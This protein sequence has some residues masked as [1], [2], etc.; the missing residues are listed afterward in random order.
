LY[1]VTG[2]LSASPR[3]SVSCHVI[4]LRTLLLKPAKGREP[5]T[6][7]VAGSGQV[8]RCAVETRADL[9]FVLSA[10]LYR[11]LGTGS[12]ASFLPYGNA[13]DQ[14]EQL[15]REHVM[16][17]AGNVPVIA[18]I[19]GHDPTRPL[20]ERFQR[21]RALGVSGVVNWPAVGFVDGT[22]RALIEAEG[23]G[24]DAE[25]DMLQQARAAGFSTFG[26][27]LQPEDVERLAPGADAFVLDLG[28]TRSV[29]DVQTKGDE[30]RQAIARLNSMMRAAE[31]S[32]PNRLCLAFGGPITEAEDV[33]QIFRHSGVHGFAGGSV[34]ER[35]P[36]HDAVSSTIRR[37][38]SVA[39][40]RLA[41]S[42]AHSFGDMIGC[43]S[44]MRQVFDLIR[45]AAP[46]DVNICIEG[47]SGT[48]KELVATQLHRLSKRADQPFVTLNCG[49]LPES[50]LESELFGH[51]KGAFTGAERRRPGKFELAHRG[52]LFLDEIGDLSPRGQVALLRVLQQREVIRVG[53]ETPIPVDV[54]VFCASNRPLARLVEVGDFRADLYYR[55]NALTIELPPLR[56]RPEDLPPLVEAVLAELRVRLGRPGLRLSMAFEEKLRQHAWPGNVREL[57]HVITQ[58]ALREEEPLLGGT[59]FIPQAAR[60]ERRS[61]DGFTDQFSTESRRTRAEQA[62]R[63]ANGNKSRAA[64]TLGVTRKT[65]YA[66]LRET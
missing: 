43:G 49:A 23:L 22:L 32:G 61:L 12:L 13:N 38:K 37:F 39:A 24:V 6:A 53:G 14:T 65:F 31:R 29:R 55:L 51:E 46:H 54:R 2:A 45:R 40:G 20:G 66:W 9:L 42:E 3:L 5:L 1:T 60:P 15:L 26:F 17:R 50:L 27:A 33:E 10:G 16:P 35:I 59:F 36:V 34:F 58:A 8:T 30:L 28:L 64:A 25:L 52:T 7:V 18:G 4:D 11:T 48:G 57:Q 21:L 63:L 41:R 47:E 44:T 62:L 56:A 19:L